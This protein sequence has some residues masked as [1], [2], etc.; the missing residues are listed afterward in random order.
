[1]R[2]QPRTS[3]TSAQRTAGRIKNACFSQCPAAAFHGNL[4]GMSILDKPL[5]A[6][7]RKPQLELGPP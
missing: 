6:R 2:G 7:T 3:S 5:R 4:P 1:M